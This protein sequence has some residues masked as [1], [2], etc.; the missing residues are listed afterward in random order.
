MLGDLE[1]TLAE[2]EK[3]VEEANMALY[4]VLGGVLFLQ[5][6][7]AFGSTWWWIR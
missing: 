1:G 4:M 2:V 5:V 3:E 6:I 7:L